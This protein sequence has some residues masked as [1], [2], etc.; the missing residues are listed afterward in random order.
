MDPCRY[1]I[2]RDQIID[3]NI[4]TTFI[5]E[6][7]PLLL[8]IV[9]SHNHPTQSNVYQL[10]SIQWI[11]FQKVFRTICTLDQLNPYYRQW[12]LYNIS[13][14]MYY[15]LTFDHVKNDKTMILYV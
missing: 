8:V 9:I 3:D 14:H 15:S 6:D 12:K 10:D 1:E 5:S 13:N 11:E 7:E 4:H 2:D